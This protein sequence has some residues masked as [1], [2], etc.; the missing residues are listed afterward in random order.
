[1]S[2]LGDLFPIEQSSLYQRD[3]EERA[4][5]DRIKWLESEKI[6]ESITPDRAKWI[7]ETR[8]R[9]GWIRAWISGHS[10]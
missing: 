7:W 5:I 4:E 2:N 1:M 9:T 10:T 6:G 8:Y 3:K